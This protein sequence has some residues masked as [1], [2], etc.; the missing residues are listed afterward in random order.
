MSDL[1]KGK[2]KVVLFRDAFRKEKKKDIAAHS[3]EGTL[4]LWGY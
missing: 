3:N 2:G 1:G 4:G